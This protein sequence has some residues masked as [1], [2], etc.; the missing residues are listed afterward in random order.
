MMKI[1]IG[2]PTGGEGLMYPAP[3]ADP[4][5][6]ADLAVEVEELGFDSIWANDHI[7]TQHYVSQQFDAPPRYLDPLAFLSHVAARTN[8]IRLATCIVVLS[9]RH[10][11]V[12]AK[13]IA[14]I[15][16]LS[17][18]RAVLGVGIG[19]YPEESRSLHPD[20]RLHRGRH[21]DEALEALG[22]LFT[23][24]RASYHGQYVRFEDLESYPKPLQAPLPVLS[25]GNSE[26]SRSRAARF[27]SGWMPASQRPEDLVAGIADIRA[28]AEE[29]GRSL[30]VGFE[31]APQMAICVAET[32]REA[33]GAFEASQVAHHKRSL[34]A[35][36]L[37]HQ[38]GEVEQRNLIGTPDQV[39]T[40]IR[41]YGDAGATTLPGLLVIG[42]TIEDFRRQLAVISAEVL[43]RLETPA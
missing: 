34:A 30:P 17:G 11:A 8:R 2:I 28:R 13:S 12:L 25:G 22:V 29:H 33:W 20:S 37:R 9:F 7:S 3:F 4:G 32:W 31:V 16:H 41:E 21:A 19:A 23:D 6:V 40:R 24:R 15:D 26:G 10:P 38:Q 42:D 36:T 14:T 1:G 39:V 43:P 27:A 18:G 35:S 5:Q